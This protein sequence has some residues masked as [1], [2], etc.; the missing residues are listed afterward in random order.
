MG[1]AVVKTVKLW[2]LGFLRKKFVKVR[3]QT[4]LLLR[5]SNTLKG[6]ILLKIDPPKERF[7]TFLLNCAVY[8][9]CSS[10]NREIVRLRLFDEKKL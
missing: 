1:Y 2:V 7:S 5:L 6:N 8:W 9:L 3:L 4:F 10:K